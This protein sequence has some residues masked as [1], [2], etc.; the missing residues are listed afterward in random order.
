[1]AFPWDSLVAL[2]KQY[3]DFI[4]HKPWKKKSRIFKLLQPMLFGNQSA[5]KSHHHLWIYSVAQQQ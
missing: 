3:V 1:M 2:K 5:R 4:L